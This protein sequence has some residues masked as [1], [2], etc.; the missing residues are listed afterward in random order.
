MVM[1][2]M[3]VGLHGVDRNFFRTFIS[4]RS[5]K[6]WFFSSAASGFSTSIAILQMF[7]E[8]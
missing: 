6:I 2:I 5:C 3:L 7:D 4:V 1:A 8:L